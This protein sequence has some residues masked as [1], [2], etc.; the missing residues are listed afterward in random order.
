MK[1]WA[2]IRAGFHEA[3]TMNDNKKTKHKIDCIPGLVGGGLSD[4]TISAYNY[5]LLLDDM[6]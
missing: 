5:C 2:I 4:P 3:G 1:K 6:S